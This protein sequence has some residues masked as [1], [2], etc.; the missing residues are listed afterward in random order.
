MAA[1]AGAGAAG[2]VQELTFS[3]AINQAIRQE[4]QRDPDIVVIGEDVAGA[5]GRAERTHHRGRR[6]RRRR[7]GRPRGRRSRDG[8][9]CRKGRAGA[10]A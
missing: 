10:A 5:A 8:G 7:R 1:I 9:D 2:A 6:A 3:Q 4:M